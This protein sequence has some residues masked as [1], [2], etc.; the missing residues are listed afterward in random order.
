MITGGS[1]HDVIYGGGHD[2]ITPG[3]GPT[4]IYGAHGD[5]GSG[6]HWSFGQG[7]GHGIG[8]DTIDGGGSTDPGHGHGQSGHDTMVGFGDVGHDAISSGGQNPQNVDHV[9]ATA[10]AHDG[11]TVITMP[12]GTTMTL[13]GTTNIDHIFPH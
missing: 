9:L 7:G 11:N 6:G 13:V 1:G 4:T 10:Q 8:G 3:T 12:N 5:D 2:T